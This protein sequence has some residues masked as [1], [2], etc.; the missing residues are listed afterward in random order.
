MNSITSVL[1]NTTAPQ[2]GDQIR[3]PAT[4]FMRDQI[5]DAFDRPKSQIEQY[6]KLRRSHGQVTQVPGQSLHITTEYPADSSNRPP[7]PGLVPTSG[8][9]SSG[10]RKNVYGL[11]P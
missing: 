6:I 2:D 8:K 4:P 7:G 3:E 10:T 5:T 11:N 9:R 1:P